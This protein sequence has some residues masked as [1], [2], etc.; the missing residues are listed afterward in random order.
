MTKTAFKQVDNEIKQYRVQ[1]TRLHSEL[2][3]LEDYLD[4]LEARR[5]SLGKTSHTQ[6]EM[7][8]RY[9]NK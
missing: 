7:E 6:A 1:M 2:E 5:C 8:K 3:D 4:I 9:Q